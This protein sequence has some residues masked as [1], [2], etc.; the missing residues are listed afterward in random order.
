MLAIFIVQEHSFGAVELYSLHLTESYSVMCVNGNI[1][2]IQ[3][4][5]MKDCDTGIRNKCS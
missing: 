4:F 1:L 2:V 3:C 5:P